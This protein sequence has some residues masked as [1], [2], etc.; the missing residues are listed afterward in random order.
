VDRKKLTPPRRIWRTTHDAPMGEFIDIDLTT[1][2]NAAGV[3]D[4]QARVLDPAPVV[5]W[6]SS[7]YDLLNGLEVNDD[8][9]SIPGELFDELFRR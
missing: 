6:R 1:P 3:T 2:L 5:D 8:E 9:A 7:S 4:V